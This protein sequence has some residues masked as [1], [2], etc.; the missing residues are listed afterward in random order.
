MTAAGGRIWRSVVI[1]TVT[2]GLKC[3]PEMTASVWI[4]MNS[5]NAWTSP[6]TDQ[7]MNG[8]TGEPGVGLTTN[9]DTTIVM[10]K[11]SANV[12][13]N[14][15]AN[16]AGPRATYVSTTGSRAGSGTGAP[17]GWASISGPPS[18]LAQTAGQH[19]TISGR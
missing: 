13:M 4:S 19:K 10:K 16:A 12:P 9:S 8:C 3:A 15:A 7:S 2:A 17:T 11:T 1:A 18:A 6:I 5:R 14:S